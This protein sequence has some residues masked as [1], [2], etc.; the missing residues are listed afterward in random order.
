MRLFAAVRNGL[1]V[2][3]VL[4]YCLFP[5]T[6]QQHLFIA[7]PLYVGSYSSYGDDVIDLSTEK[8][9]CPVTS[10]PAFSYCHVGIPSILRCFRNHP[11]N[12]RQLPTRI[13]ERLSMRSIVNPSFSRTHRVVTA[14]SPL[15]ASRIGSSHGS[16]V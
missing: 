13:S 8:R 3:T 12:L 5:N 6:Y 4:P 16:A 14:D 11:M 10:V 7:T 15:M 1:G 9:N 2:T